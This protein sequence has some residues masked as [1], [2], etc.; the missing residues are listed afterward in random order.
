[1]STPLLV[2]VQQILQSTE[3]FSE[4][5]VALKLDNTS[6]SHTAVMQSLQT[7]LSSLP[8]PTRLEILRV[9]AE[10]EASD[11]LGKRRPTS[12]PPFHLSIF[13]LKRKHVRMGGGGACLFA[14]RNMQ[15]FAISMTNWLLVTCLFPTK[16]SKQT[17]KASH[18]N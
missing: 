15:I 8:E 12:Q 18:I 14:Q 11:S 5:I 6:A 7:F 16:A 13:T 3:L 17:H 10:E 9:F 1:M 2:K 4:Y